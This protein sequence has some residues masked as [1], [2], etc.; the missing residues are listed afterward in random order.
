MSDMLFRLAVINLFGDEVITFRWFQVLPGIFGY[1]RV[2]L[3]YLRV[4]LGTFVYFWLLLGA[5]V[6]LGTW[7]ILGT[8][9]YFMV[10]SGTFGYSLVLSDTFWYFLVLSG[11]F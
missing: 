11:T 2:Y 6:L 1:L 9:W 7:V 10:L 4:L 8:F 5:Y 3:G